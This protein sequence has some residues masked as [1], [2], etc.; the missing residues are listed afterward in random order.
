MWPD[1]E[2]QSNLNIYLLHSLE[3]AKADAALRRD[4]LA[5]DQPITLLAPTHELIIHPSIL[6]DPTEA[7]LSTTTITHTRLKL[8]I[9]PFQCDSG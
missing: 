2:S 6:L 7:A 5:K 1:C 3:T 8:R 4:F 9:A